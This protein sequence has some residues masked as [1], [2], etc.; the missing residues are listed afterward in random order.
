[1]TA[2]VGGSAVRTWDVRTG[3]LSE[4]SLGPVARA[5]SVE[6]TTD[7]LLLVGTDEGFLHALTPAMQPRGS[8]L[9]ILDQEILGLDA[10]PNGHTVLVRGTSSRL[11]VDYLSGTNQRVTDLV[12]KFS[13]DGRRLAVLDEHGAVGLKN[14]DTM[15]W[16]AQPD[17]SRPFG[18]QSLAFSRDGAWLASSTNG[19]VG[20]WNGQTG[21]FAGSAQLEGHVVVGFSEDSS[22]LVIASTDGAAVK[23]WDLRPESWVNAACRAAGRDLTAAEW[24]SSLPD[25]PFG[26]VC[27]STS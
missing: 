18:G 23:T 11:L 5:A 8:P 16:I 17:L 27:P 15:S 3:K 6:Y 4:Y 22:T 21:A 10:S 19:K 24:Q 12:G 25:R 7:G 14:A 2:V 1:M 9:K 13:P 26:S 20:L